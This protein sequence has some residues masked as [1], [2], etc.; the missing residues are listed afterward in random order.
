MVIEG[1]TCD[2]CDD[3]NRENT[4]G[5]TFNGTTNVAL[6]NST[7]HYSPTAIIFYDVSG[8]ISL[9]NNNQTEVIV[10]LSSFRI[11]SVVLFVGV[12]L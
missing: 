6:V 10:E 7:F 5:V 4:A 2:K 9:T 8:T 3:P 11:H 12:Q 1:I